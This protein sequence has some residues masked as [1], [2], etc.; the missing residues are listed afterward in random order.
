MARNSQRGLRRPASLALAVVAVLA[1]VGCAAEPSADPSGGAGVTPAAGATPT[2]ELANPAS[3][4]SSGNPASRDQAA[5]SAGSANPASRVNPATS[6]SRQRPA[7]RPSC[8]H[9]SAFA[10]SLVSDYHGWASPV[11]AAQQFARQSDPSGYGTP[12][13]VWTPSAPDQSGVTLIATDL[14]LH[15]VRLPNGRWAIDSGERCD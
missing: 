14:M 8:Q 6:A 1:L 7:S 13:T 3:A 2:A 15:A 9:G 11:E 5:R 12:S 4:A 10:L